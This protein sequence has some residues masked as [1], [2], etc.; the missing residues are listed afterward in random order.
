MSDVTRMLEDTAERLLREHCTRAVHAEAEAGIWPAALWQALEES[1]LT[2]ALTPEEAGGAGLPL[3][4]VLGLLRIA[5]RHAAPVPLAE[6]LCGNWLAAACG[7]AV[8][9]GAVSIAPVMRSETLRIAPIE[10]GWRLTGRAT[11][12]PW[13]RHVARLAVL[14]LDE[15][16]APHVALVPR[17]ALA[18]LSRQQNIAL[19][20]RD[21][22]TIDASLPAHAAAPFPGAVHAARALGAAMRTAQIAGGLERALE[23]CVSYSQQRVQFGRTISKFQAIQHNLATLAAEAAAASAAVGLAAEG[24]AGGPDLLLVA[25]AKG[26]ASEAASIGAAIAHQSHGAIGFTWEYPLN[27]ATRRL[28][29]WRDEFGNEAEWYPIVADPV[30]TGDAAAIWPAMTRRRAPGTAEAA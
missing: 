13:A 15:D 18:T 19:E 14:A 4:D 1:G 23:L 10:G 27:L 9:P 30:L 8:E 12:V 6:T 20:P 16:G 2:L 26:R 3:L 22:I 11:R 28:W 17:A 5:A 21:T 7:L 25:A 24:I 29:S